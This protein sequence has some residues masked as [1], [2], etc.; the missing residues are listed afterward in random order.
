MNNNTISS[1]S[2]RFRQQQHIHSDVLHSSLY[3]KDLEKNDFGFYACI[4]ESKAGRSEAIIELKEHYHLIP[5]TTIISSV[6]LSTTTVRTQI[7]KRNKS[8]KEKFF[9]KK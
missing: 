7:L 6:E 8:K 5:I 4:A 3:I 2:T 9:V 1:Q